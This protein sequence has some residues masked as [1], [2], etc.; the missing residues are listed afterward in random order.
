MQPTSRL[1]TRWK[2]HGVEFVPVLE[3]AGEGIRVGSDADA[4]HFEPASRTWLHGASEN[5]LQVIG[6]T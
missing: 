3:G 2:K 4:S 5:L 6:T 1:S